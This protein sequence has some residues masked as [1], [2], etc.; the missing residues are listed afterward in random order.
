[1]KIDVG[2]KRVCFFIL[3][4]IKDNTGYI[5]CMAVEGEKGYYLT[6]WN[7]GKDIELAEK[8]AKKKNRMLELTE[9]DCLKIVGSTM[10]F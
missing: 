3:E 2:G 6:D 1:M 8:C 10:R 9:A 5:P 7:W 4:T